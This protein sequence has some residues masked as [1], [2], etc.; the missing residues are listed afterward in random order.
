MDL[1]KIG[2][3]LNQVAP[4]I[5]TALGGPLAGL[6]VKTLSEAVLGKQDGNESEIVAALTGADPSKLADL[7]RVD[8]EFA[9]QMKKLDIDLA[10]LDVQDRTSAR[11]REVKSGDNLTPRILAT[12][13]VGGFFG[14][15]LTIIFKG[16][17]VDMNDAAL[18]MFGGLSAAFTAV[19]AYY[20]GSSAGSAA[21]N[22]LLRQRRP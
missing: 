3:L 9:V 5:A 10:A 2:G 22:E 20:F 6:A 19:V 18:I 16:T 12:I 8:A 7:K 1:S 15:L 14:M 4:T 13:I 17:P 21:K 11:D